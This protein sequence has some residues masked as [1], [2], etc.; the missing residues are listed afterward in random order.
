MRMDEIFFWFPMRFIVPVA[1]AGEA[2]MAMP[3]EKK[4][5]VFFKWVNVNLSWL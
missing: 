2:K 5:G 3:M 4:A 1:E